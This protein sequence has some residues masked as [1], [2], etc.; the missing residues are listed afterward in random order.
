MR[1]CIG[2]YYRLLRGYEVF[3]LFFVVLLWLMYVRTYQT[4]FPLHVGLSA[5]YGGG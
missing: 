3:F 2:E 1:D 5:I 4:T